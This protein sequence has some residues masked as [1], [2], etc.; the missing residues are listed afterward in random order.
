VRE[1]TSV[2]EADLTSVSDR[3][4]VTSL[5]WGGEEK[6]AARF[7]VDASGRKAFIGAKSGWR[8]PARN[9][10]AR[11]FGRIRATWNWRGDSKKVF[12]HH[13]HGTGTEGPDLGFP[14]W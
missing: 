5:D 4:T 6:Y 12:Y 1:E 3:V 10:I 2:I 13:L 11:R 8:Q 14:S 9:W 7:L